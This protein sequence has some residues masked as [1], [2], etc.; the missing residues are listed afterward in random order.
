[1]GPSCNSLILCV[2]AQDLV[3][4]FS[5]S[6]WLIVDLTLYDG[7]RFRCVYLGKCSSSFC[8]YVWHLGM[9]SHRIL[10]FLLLILFC[11]ELHL[12]L[13]FSQS[14]TGGL[15]VVDQ[16]GTGSFF[17]VLIKIL[18]DNIMDQVCFPFTFA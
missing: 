14:R 4:T 11:S 16:L 6:F 10:C 13:S 17:C 7:S 9:A 18:E 3:G 2:A 15:L 12:I 8:M 5:S 1:M